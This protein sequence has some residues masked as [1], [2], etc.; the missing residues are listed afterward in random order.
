[1]QDFKI[2]TDVIFNMMRHVFRSHGIECC[3]ILIG[4][5]GLVQYS[6]SMAN[7]AEFP[8]IEYAFNPEEQ[9]EVWHTAG[10]RKMDIM[11]VY[12]SHVRGE[13]YPSAGDIHMAA[14]PSFHYVILTQSSIRSFRIADAEVT[15]EK[16]VLEY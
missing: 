1:M 2:P 16:V 10:E 15:E 11:G 3:G 6:H 9:I 7:I 8:D 12:H 13:A 5:N 14:Y 4:R